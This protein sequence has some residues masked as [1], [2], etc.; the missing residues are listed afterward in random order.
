MRVYI[1][2]DDHFYVTDEARNLLQNE[3]HIRRKYLFEMYKLLF[4]YR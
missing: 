3:Q 2:S 4:E 1:K